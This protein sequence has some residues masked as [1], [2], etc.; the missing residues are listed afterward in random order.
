ML[1]SLNKQA[2]TAPMIQAISEPA[3][4]AAERRYVEM[5]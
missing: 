1:I 4:M 2:T 3:W 5:A